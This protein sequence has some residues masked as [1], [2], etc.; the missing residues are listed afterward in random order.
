MTSSILLL[1]FYSVSSS[2]FH[3]LLNVS[4]RAKENIIGSQKQ[5]F[6]L[7]RLFF[8][9]LLFFLLLLVG[10]CVCKA[11]L[12]VPRMSVLVSGN[13]VYKRKNFFHIFFFPPIFTN[14]N[15]NSILITLKDFSPNFLL[16]LSFQEIVSSP[17]IRSK[18]SQ[19]RWISVLSFSFNFL[20]QER[21]I[22]N[23]FS[24]S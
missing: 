20:A 13:F 16:Q 23:G 11:E 3:L 4:H 7:P 17:W 5:H 24:F 8:S 21:I 22:F 10:V 15:E 14:N 6:H 2:Q 18:K 9:F 19:F 12:D 1:S